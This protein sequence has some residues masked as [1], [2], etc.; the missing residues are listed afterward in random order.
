MLFDA[1]TFPDINPAAL[2]LGP[3]E[4]FGLEL[5]PFPLRWY[6]LAYIAGLVLGWRWMVHLIRSK[7]IWG[8]AKPALSVP[9][10]DD[11]LMWATLG[12]ILGG[13]LGYV[14]FYKPDMIWL[15]PAQILQIWSGGMSFHG[16]LIGVAL[17]TFW[18][19]R[20]L[21]VDEDAYLA[22]VRAKALKKAP[23]KPQKGLIQIKGIGW[24]KS[25]DNDE[26]MNNTR[27]QRIDLMRLGD[28]VAV[29]APIGLFFGRIANFINAELYGRATT[30][31]WGMV[32]PAN[33]Y[34]WNERRWRWE[35]LTQPR[36]P[37]QLYEA[38]LE[39]LALFAILNVA[40]WKFKSLQRPGLNIGLFLLSYGLFRA[41][42]ET[43]REPDAHM[44]EALRG[45]ITM[46]MLL[47]LPMIAVGAWLIWRA[48]K[49]PAVATA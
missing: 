32:F 34:D 11:Y 40:T 33:G 25:S 47:S 3:F 39:G 42:L 26:A 8:G 1:L 41:L 36:H 15:D 48:Y 18:F 10:A 16:G 2:T 22:A 43:V 30:L 14:F 29:C 27:T 44:P 37:S 20:R 7:Q 28:V 38:V 9:Q 35:V 31:P 46:G 12:V 5:G 45:I 4:L 19:A 24:I 49:T 13:R 17:A 6:A 21:H 23:E